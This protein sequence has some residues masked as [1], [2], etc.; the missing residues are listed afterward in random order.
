MA[1]I[2]DCQLFVLGWRDAFQS[3][4]LLLLSFIFKNLNKA[5]SLSSSKN[6]GMIALQCLVNARRNI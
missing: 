6:L 1:N 3:S 5:K 2:L 4:E